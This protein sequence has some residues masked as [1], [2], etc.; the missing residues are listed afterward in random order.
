M[1]GARSCWDPATDLVCVCVCVCVWR[2]GSS[3]VSKIG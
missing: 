3:E 1:L 2:G